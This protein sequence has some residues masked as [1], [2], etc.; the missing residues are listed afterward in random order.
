MHVVSRLSRDHST[1]AG[2]CIVFTRTHVDDNAA[3]FEHKNNSEKKKNYFGEKRRR[4][5]IETRNM[6]RILERKEKTGTICSLYFFSHS[7]FVSAKRF[8]LLLLDT[9]CGVWLL[10]KWIFFCV[11][12]TRLIA[13]CAVYRYSIYDSWRRHNSRPRHHLQI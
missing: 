2:H 3:Y 1:I 13:L 11:Y 5:R 7:A 9:L 4:R 8:H 10:P 6:K 12:Q